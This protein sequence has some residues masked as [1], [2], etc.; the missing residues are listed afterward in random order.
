[1]VTIAPPVP[2]IKTQLREAVNNIQQFS[3]KNVSE[4]TL[5]TCCRGEIHERSFQELFSHVLN[6]F[7][8]N[9]KNM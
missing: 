7:I 2:P 8:E 4:N 9:C 3:G 5:L 6:N 1:M